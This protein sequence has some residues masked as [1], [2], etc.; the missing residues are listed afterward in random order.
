[1]DDDLLLVVDGA[2]NVYLGGSGGRYICL[3]TRDS[4]LIFPA[5]VFGLAFYFN[6]DL[7]AETKPS[8]AHITVLVSYSDV[9]LND[10]RFG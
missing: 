5:R 9:S 1:M 6:S 8:V 3:N 2:S 4:A 10:E 7:D